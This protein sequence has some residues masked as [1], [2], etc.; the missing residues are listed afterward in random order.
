MTA[1]VGYD[2]A[3]TPADPDR[4]AP[5]LH[6][7]LTHPNSAFWGMAALDVAQVRD[8]LSAIVCDEHQDAWLGVVDGVPLFFAE[9][10]DPRHRVLAGIHDALPGD[11]GMHILVA[12]PAGERRPGLTDAAFAAVM[13]CCFHTLG[14]DRV[15]VEPDV[16]NTRIAA[17]NRRAGFR[18]LREVDVPEGGGVKRAAL[19]VCTRADHA[20]SELGGLS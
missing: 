11:L 12:P 15:V 7:W 8:Y 9:T 14:A 6:R 2:I 4:D 16:R 20:A 17:K 10:Y 13:D 19:S 1:T 18:V 3:L 5:E